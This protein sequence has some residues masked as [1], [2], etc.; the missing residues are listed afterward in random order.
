MDEDDAVGVPLPRLD[1]AL[2]E[3]EVEAHHEEDER[4]AHQPGNELPCGAVEGL[5]IRRVHVSM[6]SFL[7]KDGYCS[8]MR[9]AAA[10][11]IGARASERS[12]KPPTIMK[13]AEGLIATATACEAP[14]PKM[15]TGM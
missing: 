13:C 14:A 7:L 11:A 15:S 4:G 5:K 8:A 12:V 6:T 9:S 1:R 3:P 2:E 10:T